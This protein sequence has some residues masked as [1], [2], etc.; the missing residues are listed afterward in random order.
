M[1]QDEI[2]AVDTSV[3]TG[4]ISRFLLTSYLKIEIMQSHDS[5]VDGNV[6]SKGEKDAHSGKRS[7]CVGHARRRPCVPLRPCML[8]RTAQTFGA[9][10]M[11]D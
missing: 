8:V 3:P 4:R 10:M 2:G 1:E 9:D 6:S 7:C 11:C 5:V